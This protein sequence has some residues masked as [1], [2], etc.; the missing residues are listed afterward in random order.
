MTNGEARA[1]EREYNQ[2]VEKGRV[3]WAEAVA[4]AKRC[5]EIQEIFKANDVPYDEVALLFGAEMEI[6]VVG[7]DDKKVNP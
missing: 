3:L 7:P 2:I 6:E 5:N 1:L 4:M